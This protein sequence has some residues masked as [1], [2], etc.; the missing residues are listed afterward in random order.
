LYLDLFRLCKGVSD[1]IVGVVQYNRRIDVVESWFLTEWSTK[2]TTSVCTGDWRS[3][4]IKR[5]TTSFRSLSATFTRETII[6]D[7]LF[8][9]A[10]GDVQLPQPTVLELQRVLSSHKK[11]GSNLAIS[12]GLFVLSSFL[13]V[14]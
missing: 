5:K 9:E 2:L 14:F 11:H 1:E 13:I 8:E 4:E 3:L 10:V 12:F 7:G 6:M